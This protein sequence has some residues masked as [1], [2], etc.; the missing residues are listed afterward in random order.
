MLFS[1]VFNRAGTPY[2]ELTSVH[3]ENQAYCARNRIF[4][5]KDL[6]LYIFFLLLQRSILIYTHMVT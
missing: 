1:I 2:P 6:I 4:L 5:Q 3:Q